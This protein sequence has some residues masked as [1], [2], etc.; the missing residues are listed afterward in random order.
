MDSTA[1]AEAP[2]STP[3][4]VWTPRRELLQSRITRRSS[5]LGI[6]YRAAIDLLE[7]DVVSSSARHRIVMIAHNVRELLLNAPDLFDDVEKPKR[8]TTDTVGALNALGIAWDAER[9]SL[10]D[11]TNYKR[12][13]K[14]KRDP[15]IVRGGL[16]AAVGW[17]ITEHRRGTANNRARQSA[18]VL[19]RPGSREDPTL[20]AWLD[21]QAWFHR[22]AHLSSSKDN[23]VVPNDEDVLQQLQIVED[24]LF[25]RLSPFFDVK[26]ELD[27]LLAEANAAYLE[28]RHSEGVAQE[29]AVGEQ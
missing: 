27:G 22:H 12:F 17:A 13:R 3:P 23:G 18:T 24:V 19:G 1:G 8:G 7:G 21:A 4:R 9:D 28:D 5:D 26:D 29:E 6:L 20:R 11:H 15:F 16:L 10:G 14:D 25:S 2:P